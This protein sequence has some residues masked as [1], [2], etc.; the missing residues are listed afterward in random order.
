MDQDYFPTA[1]MREVIDYLH[2][3]GQ[4]YGMVNV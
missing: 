1:R 3:H 2:K 4:R